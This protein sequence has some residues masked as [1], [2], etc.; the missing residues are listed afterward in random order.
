VFWVHRVGA[1]VCCQQNS[2]TGTLERLFEEYREPET[3]KSEE[4]EYETE[5]ES[6]D[7]KPETKLAWYKLAEELEELA[8]ELEELQI[9]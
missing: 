9:A 1:G 4:T 5:T 8:N 7:P 2:D 6:E 3:T